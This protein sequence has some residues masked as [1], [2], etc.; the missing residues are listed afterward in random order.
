V[1]KQAKARLQMALIVFITAIAL[2]EI[3]SWVA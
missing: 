3:Y 2:V 1:T